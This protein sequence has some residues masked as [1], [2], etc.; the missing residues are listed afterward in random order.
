MGELERFTREMSFE[1]EV[2]DIYKPGEQ[3]LEGGQPAILAIT[4]KLYKQKSKG[5]PTSKYILDFGRPKLVVKKKVRENKQ[6]PA[7][8]RNLSKRLRTS[9]SSKSLAR[10]QPPSAEVK[11]PVSRT[12][13]QHSNRKSQCSIKSPTARSLLEP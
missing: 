9:S 3:S 13:P 12:K 8:I 11:K 10:C 2:F 5:K 6:L 7:D 1:T 4:Y